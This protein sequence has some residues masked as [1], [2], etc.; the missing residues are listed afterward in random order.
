MK[1]EANKVVSFHYTLSE[2]GGEQLEASDRGHPMTYVVGHGNVLAGLE[3]AMLGR[4]VGDKFEV[5]LSP[6]EGYGA[7]K[8]N[9]EQRIAI[10]HVVTPGKKKPN[11]RVGQA[12]KINTEKG[13]RDVRVLK[14]GKFNIDVDTNHPLAGLDLSFNIEVADVRDATS[15]EINH[16]HV[17]GPGGHAH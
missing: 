12:V 17:H 8:D 5:T 3:R 10:K 2:V 16:R 1:I 7:R 15:E 4:Q 13:P 14:V 6:A 11:L 9:A